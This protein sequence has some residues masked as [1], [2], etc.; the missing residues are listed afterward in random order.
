MNFNKHS[1]LQGEHSFLSPSKYHWINYDEDKIGSAYLKFLAAQKGTQLHDFACQCIR[2]GIKLPKNKQTLNSYVNDALGFR[3]IPEQPLFYSENA[4]GTADAISFRDKILRIHDLKT[5]VSPV[6][7]SQLEIYVA[8][9]CLEYEMNPKKIDIELRLYQSDEIVVHKPEWES[10]QDIMKKVVSFDERI[11]LI[12]T[13]L[14][15]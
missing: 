4:F 5:G 2:L 13:D 10:I 3:M 9:F 11:N 15:D 6:S 8:F 14:E 1:N 7:M 12:K